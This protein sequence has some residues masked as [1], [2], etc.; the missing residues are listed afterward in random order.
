MCGILGFYKSGNGSMDHTR[1][2][3]ALGSI[4][5]RGPDDEGVWNAENVWLG[6]R[7]LSI[8]DLSKAGHQPMM[9]KNERFVIT[10]NGE[11]FNFIELR[12]ALIR[13]GYTFRTQT[14]T[15]VLLAIFQ[16]YGNDGL[17]FLNGFFA[18][19]IYDRLERELFI[20]RDRYGIK[21]LYY[22][23]GLPY[24]AFGSELSVFSKLGIRFDLDP[25]S[26]GLYIQLNYIPAP[27]TIYKAVKKLEPGHFIRF[28]LDDKQ[29]EIYPG[30]STCWY[31]LPDQEQII[32]IPYK[33]ACQHLYSKLDQSVQRRLISDVPLGTFLSGGIDSSIVTALASRYT[34]EL[35]TFSIGFKDEPEFD[36]TKYAI[37]VARHCNTR[38]TVFSLSGDDLLE[39]LPGMAASQHEP[40]ADSSALAVYILSRETRKHV[41]VALSGDGSDELFA[42]Y[43]KHRAE[44]LLQQRTGLKTISSILARTLHPLKGSRQTKAGN[45]LRQLHRF[46]EGAGLH[47]AD[48]YWKWCCLSSARESEDLLHHD[49]LPELREEITIRQNY[50]TRYLSGNYDVNEV[51]RNDFHLVLQGDMLTK[52]D[53][54]SMAHGLEVRVPFLDYELVDFAFRLPANYKIDRRHQKKI[55][56]DTFAGLLP[57]GLFNRPKK[58]FEIPLKN[59]FRGKLKKEIL[60]VLSESNIKQQGIF[61]PTEVQKIVRFLDSSQQGDM[62]A[63]IWALLMFQYWW[64]KTS[65]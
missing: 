54:M 49:I 51:L 53:M 60:E 26:L 7:R 15:E 14:D 50:L 48:R 21:P 9:S 41:T 63:R 37:E 32:T 65:S 10:F 30:A 40:F 17:S 24:F 56:K 20:A 46:A 35:Q 45:R 6:H 19:C 42:G 34:D 5:H 36:E 58:G 43:R 3:A 2:S 52:V 23:A 11:I 62:N 39:A 55:L 33:E 18:F 12:E 61:E 4:A 31:S 57:E 22:T 44:W 13:K 38:H 47:H 27:Y 1:F 64:Q 29:P 28:R 59:W 25:A 16:E 8:I